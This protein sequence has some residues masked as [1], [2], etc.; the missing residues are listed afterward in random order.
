MRLLRDLPITRKLT[1]II[2]IAC[3]L[4]L[5][6]AFS[7]YLLTDSIDAQR[8]AI[9][10]LQVLARV[11]ATNS[12]LG[13][14]FSDTENVQNILSALS[15]DSQI[16]A[17]TIY[18]PD[19]SILTRYDRDQ[20]SAQPLSAKDENDLFSNHYVFHWH[21]LHVLESIRLNG[22]SV[23]YVHIHSNL[24]AFYDRLLHKL[25]TG[26]CFI[27][28]AIS[29]ALL[30]AK[31]LHHFISQPIVRL[32]YAMEKVSTAQNYNLRVSN[33][34]RDE[35]GSLIDGFNNMLQEIHQRDEQLKQHQLL[36]E[37]EVSERTLDLSRTND[38]LQ[39]AIEMTTNAK[40]DAEAASRAKSEFLAR[41]SHEIRTPINGVLG[42]TELLLNTE[43]NPKQRN[44]AETVSRSGTALLD[45][46]ND[47]LDFSK[48][49]AGRLELQSI[50]FDIRNLLEDLGELFAERAQSKNLELIVSIPANTHTTFRGDPTR[51]RQ[52]LTNLL[53]NAI[54]FTEQ[55][56]VLLRLSLLAETATKARLRLEVQDSGAGI[57]AQDQ[58]HIFDAFAQGD[59][60]Y[61]R[62][63]SGTGLGFDHLQRID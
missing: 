7:A 25:L 60:S 41:M 32:A 29:T 28:L 8:R 27:I 48:I 62:R 17:A 15:A 57:A 30:I 31:R 61:S 20:Q 14:V 35:I 13:T 43:L 39:K 5:F 53:G 1:Y 2:T 58:Q 22:E 56:E 37:Q 46:I 11:I 6:G 4:A 59:G 45:V 9:A 3:G 10:D 52:I 19:R 55:G 50:P 38:E 21:E 44:F 63:H 24:N 36:L 16:T 47:I 49:E 33:D 34:S 23:G 12:A 40:E 26:T 51:L 18:L 42:M 54:K